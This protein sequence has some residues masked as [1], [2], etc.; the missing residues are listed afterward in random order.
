MLSVIAG[1]RRRES[2]QQPPPAQS[3]RIVLGE[4]KSRGHRHKKSHGRRNPE[5][6]SRT[7]TR[8]GSDFLRLHQNTRRKEHRGGMADRQRR[9]SPPRRTLEGHE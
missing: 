6:Q 5:L 8:P 3:A 2:N 1:A 7:D 4:W 9:F